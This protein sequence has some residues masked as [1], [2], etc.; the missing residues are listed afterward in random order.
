MKDK[1]CFIC[2]F[3]S[4]LTD[5]NTHVNHIYSQTGENIKINLCW[6]HSVEFFKLG[7]VKFFIKYKADFHGCYGSE[8]DDA[9]IE[10]SGVFKKKNSN[11]WFGS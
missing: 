7:Q 8:M 9:I 3:K 11:Y 6:S 1:R 2:K 5:N 10:K 4:H